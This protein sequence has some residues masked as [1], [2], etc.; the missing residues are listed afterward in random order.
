[1]KTK[2]VYVLTCSPEGTYI[3]Q[4]L[5]SIWSAK[6]HNPGAHIVLITDDMTNSLL[7]G[8]RGEVLSYIS[9]KIV[10]S[11][12]DKDSSMMYRSRWLKTNVR[13]IVEGDYLFI[14]CDTIITSDLSKI[15]KM[16]SAIALSR[17]ENINLSD[18]SPLVVQPIVDKCSLIGI[19]IMKEICYYN[20]GVMY[21]KDVPETHDLY[22]LWHTTWEN[23]LELGVTVDQ[24]SFAKANI[25]CGRIVDLLDDKWNTIV[26]SQ[27]NTIYDS[28]ILHFWHGVSFLYNSA[29]TSYLCNNGL[30]DIIKY[31][32][33]HPVETFI[34]FDNRVCKY[35][36]KGFLSLFKTMARVF[37]Q[38]GQEIDSSF[39]DF[40]YRTGVSSW[41]V[42]ALSRRNYRIAALIIV[43]HKWYYINLSGKFVYKSNYFSK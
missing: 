22:D 33:L 38:Y 34:P 10:V 37:S 39:S 26:C 5:M 3:E 35:T 12:S 15:D 13:S 20:S 14:D 9:E 42:K 8:T 31:Y 21:V 40:D 29:V 30:T 2:L 18:A 36:Y 41:A 24:P 25:E 17:D 28:Y 11:F 16:T 43:M 7:S 6:Y 1:M 19:D 27:V 4:A 23:G 32:I